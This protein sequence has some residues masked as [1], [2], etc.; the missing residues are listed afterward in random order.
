M[1]LNFAAAKIDLLIWKITED[2]GILES[3][4]FAELLS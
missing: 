2:A 4:F 1:W 3:Q